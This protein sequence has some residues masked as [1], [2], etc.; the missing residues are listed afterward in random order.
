[1]KKKYLIGLILCLMIIPFVVGCSSDD[2]TPTPTA[3][4]P[5]Q[6]LNEST[7]Q[8][9]T[10]VWE[11]LNGKAAAADLTSLAVRVGTLEG[12]VAPDLSSFTA[13]DTEFEGRIATLESYNISEIEA[14]VNYINLW[15][16]DYTEDNLTER[17]T[18]V[19]FEVFGS[20]TPTP[21][22]A[23]PTPN[24]NLLKPVAVSPTIGDL[25]VVNGSVLFEWSDCNAMAYEF[26]FGENSNNLILIDSLES[27]IQSFLWPCM[28]ADTYYFWRVR[29]ISGT[30]V[31][32][33]S[34]WFKTAP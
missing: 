19:E 2:E 6:L 13:K 14:F 26:W 27:D 24:P 11:S 23:T 7:A 25:S 16:E 1:M 32:S 5:I 22:G 10:A 34:F 18:A 20:P 33:S 17:L 28:E 31:K 4:T 21:T 8:R 9:F 29:A 30:N 15:L 12:S 3:K